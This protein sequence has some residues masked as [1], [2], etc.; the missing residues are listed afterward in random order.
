M[1]HLAFTAA[2]A[3]DLS[4]FV[5]KATGSCFTKALKGHDVSG[6]LSVESG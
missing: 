3:V 6:W 5:T 4:A 1:R 2:R